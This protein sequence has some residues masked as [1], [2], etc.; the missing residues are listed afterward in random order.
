ME[1]NN[2]VKRETKC[3]KD[4]YIIAFYKGGGVINAK[5]KIKKHMSKLIIYK[6]IIHFSDISKLKNN[7]KATSATRAV[8]FHL[9][10]V[11]YCSH[12]FW[13]YQNDDRVT[14]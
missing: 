6:I 8:K 11:L 3:T 12:T 10:F 7:N 4:M 9:S 2:I 1:I 14:F 5:T 13:R